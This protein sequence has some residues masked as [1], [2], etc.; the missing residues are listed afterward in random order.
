ML[1]YKATLYPVDGGAFNNS[2]FLNVMEVKYSFVEKVLTVNVIIPISLIS[3]KG[4]L[5]KKKN[6]FCKCRCIMS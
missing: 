6:L 4:S 1:D 2:Q 3:Y 5:L